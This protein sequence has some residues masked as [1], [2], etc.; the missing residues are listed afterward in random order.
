MK[1]RDYG[2]TLA[3]VLITLGIIGVVAAITIPGLI[4]TY[5]AHQ[6][7][8]KFL[9]AYSTIQ[10]AFKQMEADDV[11]SD[12]TDYGSNDGTRFYEVMARYLK[13]AQLCFRSNLVYPCYN[14]SNP[15]IPYKNLNGTN[16]IP[17]N[18]F[19]DG[20]IVL[21]D[22][23]LLLF[24]SATTAMGTL[25]FADLNGSDKLP[26]RLGYD[27]FVFQLIDEEIKTMGDKGT[28]Y[29]DLNNYCNF[30]RNSNF[31]GIGC[32]QKAKENADYFKTLV[33]DIK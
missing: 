17:Y 9:K 3:E 20:Q 10:Q 2:F 33:K 31:N 23:T 27:V 32:A 30:S 12:P 8:A 15:Q 5:R 29:N 18:Y 16:T 11:S 14:Y 26:N 25:F 28:I 6:L 7:R 1:K 24:E 13:P 21:L 4:T 22:G 19:D